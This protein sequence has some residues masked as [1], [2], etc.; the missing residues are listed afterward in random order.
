MDIIIQ[1]ISEFLTKSLSNTS[2]TSRK[3]VILRS[4]ERVFKKSCPKKPGY[5]W[6]FC[7]L[8]EYNQIKLYLLVVQR[9]SFLKQVKRIVKKRRDR[10][11]F[12]SYP[13]KVCELEQIRKKKSKGLGSTI[14]RIGHPE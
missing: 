7:V 8:E 14:G 6:I 4:F 2:R 5:G 12:L 9:T 13:I 3:L 11:V 1:K 10:K